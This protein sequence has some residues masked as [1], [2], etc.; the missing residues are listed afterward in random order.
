MTLLEYK[1]RLKKHDWYY[2]QSDDPRWYDSGLAEER[3][4]TKLSKTKESF[5]KAFDKEKANHFPNKKLSDG[6]K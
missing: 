1:K 6:N 3:E 2:H 5:K 4:L